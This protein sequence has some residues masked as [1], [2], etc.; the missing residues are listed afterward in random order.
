MKNRLKTLLQRPVYRYLLIGGGVYILE[1]AIIVVAQRL[2]ASAYL[3]VGLGFWIGLI[4][5]FWLQKLLAF[6]DRRLKRQV[7]VSQIVA[8]SLLVLFNFTF[9]LLATRLLIDSLPVTVIR[10][11]TLAITTVWNYYLY[12]TRIF[13]IPDSP[14]YW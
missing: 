12:K 5:S 11:L 6:G 9:T 2:G 4:T 13:K 7:L 14:L 1:L 8:F 10:T 3:A